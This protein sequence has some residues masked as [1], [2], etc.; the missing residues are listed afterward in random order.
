MDAAGIRSL[1]KECPQLDLRGDSDSVER[2]SRD[3]SSFRVEPAAVVIA[4]G[5]EDVAVAVSAAAEH[6]L[7]VTARAGGSSV[8][9][10]CLGRGL[11]LD[12]SGIDWIEVGD[13]TVSCGPGAVLDRLNR[14]LAKHDRQ[15]G[16]DV[17]SSQ[18][19]C[20][21]GLIATNA[22][23]AR[24]ATYGRF[25]DI[26][27]EASVVWADG[28]EEV[29]RP[30][31]TPERLK[32]GLESVGDGLED[33][34]ESWPKQHRSYGGYRLD[35]FQKSRDAISLVPGSEGTLCLVT[36]AKL[37][38]VPLPKERDLVLVEFDGL[39]DAL[40]AAEAL[41]ATGASAVEIL[42]SHVLAAARERGGADFL[43]EGAQAVLL[44]EYLDSER[45]AGG[46]LSE[47]LAS[48]S[49]LLNGEE[50]ESAWR[51]RMNALSLTTDVGRVPI[52]FF[53]DPA[54]KPGSAREFCESL[55]EL[56]SHF[57]FEAVIYGH[58]AATCLHVRPLCD[59]ADLSIAAKLELA[60][61]AVAEL[62]REFGGAVTGEHGWGLSRSYLARE[63]L[64]KDIYG[65]FERVKAAF[66]PQGVLNPGI[67]VGGRE[68]FTAFRP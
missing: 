35:T 21:G 44:V 52:A 6:G 63:T 67:I 62:V 1:A 38:T 48:R 19:A 17:T 27:L 16:P 3:S 14:E 22:C 8:A 23:G 59:P 55:L 30:G 24:S 36:E 61:P 18:W 15:V 32:T 41:A 5:V 31:E 29:L 13:G 66:D 28:S 51:M 57:G 40:D 10:Q 43:G 68:P 11:V 46:R 12:T 56:L 37:K 20:V 9:G 64:G 42:D 49:R 65:C 2:Y 26:L 53:E 58:A 45:P 34:L 7:S 4:R 54:V 60:A 25:G 47:G 33:A 39:L 50:A